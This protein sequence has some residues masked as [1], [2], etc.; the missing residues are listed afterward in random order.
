VKNKTT[1]PFERFLSNCTALLKIFQQFWQ[2]VTRWKKILIPILSAAGISLTTIHFWPATQK[3]TEQHLSDGSVLVENPARAKP[4]PLQL[5]D[6]SRVTLADASYIRYSTQQN[7]NTRELTIG[8][9]AEFEVKSDKRPFIVHAGSTDVRVLGT[10][11]NVMNYTDEPTTVT[12]ISGKVRISSPDGTTELQ[13]AQQATVKEGR[14]ETKT[15]ANPWSCLD[16][17]YNPPYFSFDG[18]SLDKVLRTLSR[19]YLVKISNPENLVGIPITVTLSRDTS[20]EDVL[21]VIQYIEKT[22]HID[23]KKDGDTIYVTRR[24]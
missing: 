8:G 3:A 19:W 2:L 9:Q 20:L 10:H 5:P 23:I 16:W 13:Q 7:G 12:L 22:A 14:I 15:L 21:Q 4:F 6:G 1:G 17:A 11:F 24:L 18:D